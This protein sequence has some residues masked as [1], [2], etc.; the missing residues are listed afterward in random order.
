MIGLAYKPNVDDPRES[1]TF[2]TMDHFAKQGAIV[3][4]Y[5]PYIPEIGPSREHM[6]WRGKRS[7]KWT[8]G[9]LKSCDLTLILTNHA[10]INYKELVEWSALVIDTRRAVDQKLV[11]DGQPHL[12]QSQQIWR[13]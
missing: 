9:E 3:E 12:L 6:N 2:V 5:D 8:A 11:T 7:V 4:Y 13:A 1:P 10:C